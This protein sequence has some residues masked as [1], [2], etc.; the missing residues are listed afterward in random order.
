MRRHLVMRIRRRRLLSAASLVAVMLAIATAEMACGDGGAS[1]GRTSI[2]ERNAAASAAVTYESGAGF[3]EAL[4]R[5]GVPCTKQTVTPQTVATE[6]GTIHVVDNVTC[7]YSEHDWVNGFVAW[8]S[9]FSSRYFSLYF[10]R[11]QSA[12]DEVGAQSLLLKGK[13]WFATAPTDQRL[14]DTQE[15]LGGQLIKP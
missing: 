6:W 8:P 14:F 3:V 1:G 2:D 12:G 9:E 13:L 5:A 4:E 15:A 10:E 11:Y 7:T